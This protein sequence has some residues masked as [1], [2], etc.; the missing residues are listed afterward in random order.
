MWNRFRPGKIKPVFLHQQGPALHN[1]C[2]PD[3]GALSFSKPE[4]LF[5]SD[6]YF[7]QYKSHQE[8][9]EKEPRVIRIR[10][11]SPVPLAPESP[12][13]STLSDTPNTPLKNSSD[14]PNKLSI[15]SPLTIENYQDILSF[16]QTKKENIKKSNTSAFFTIKSKKIENGM[17][18]NEEK[19]TKIDA[20]DV[21]RAFFAG[22]NFDCWFNKEKIALSTMYKV[23]ASSMPCP[24][25][26]PT[27]DAN[28]GTLDFHIELEIVNGLPYIEIENT[29]ENFAPEE[30]RTQLENLVLN[31]GL[32]P[33][34]K[35]TRSWVLIINGE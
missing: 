12:L 25:D 24:S 16:I 3:N 7:S 26:S 34:K 11:E 30:I 5:K 33:S 4:L 19:E 27:L 13:N 35:D 18:F 28:A 6:Q 21:L 9:L 1:Q 22:T 8:R 31:L 29:Q 15:E 23:N 17:E 10:T 20:P 14:S 32:D 2:N